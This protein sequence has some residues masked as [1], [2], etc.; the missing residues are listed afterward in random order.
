MRVIAGQYRGR[1]LKAP[2]GSTTR[3]TTDRV[4]ETLMSSLMS[5]YGP[6]D[7]AHVLDAFAGS[8]A[9]GIECLSRGAAFA[10]FFERDRGALEALRSNISMLKLPTERARVFKADVMKNPPLFGGGAYDI[11]FLDPPYAYEPEDVFAL[12]RALVDANR[13][14][15]DAVVSYEHAAATAIMPALNECLPCME[16]LSSK[17]FGDTAIDFLGFARQQ[18][19]ASERG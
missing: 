8:G 7:G 12:V 16:V 13:L 1:P 9:L 17:R 6:F 11:V 2:K 18:H 5:A 14:S 10:H 15:D 19:D 4:K 3:P